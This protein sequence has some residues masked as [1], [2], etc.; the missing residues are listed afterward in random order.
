MTHR[1][2]AVAIAAVAAAAALAG[3]TAPAPPTA[4]N[5][6]QPAADA[7]VYRCA[8]G[9]MVEARYRRSDDTLTV[10]YTG[11]LVLMHHAISADG[12]RYAG[13]GLE[14]WSRGSNIG[15][16]GTLFRHEA[17]GSTGAVIET[18]TLAIAPP[19]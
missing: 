17:D 14:W 4:A 18:C 5:A 15:A 16:P 10:R 2:V 9:E 3:C 19:R 1:P 13:E 11:Q 12:A 7:W 6:E 8:S